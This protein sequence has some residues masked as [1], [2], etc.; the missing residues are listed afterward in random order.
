VIGQLDKLGPQ[1]TAALEVFLRIGDEA[2]LSQAYELGRLAM[3]GGLGVLDMAS[4]HH[5]ALGALFATISPAEQ[6]RLTRS[7]ADFFTELLSPFEMSIRGYRAANEKLQ[8]LNES[9]RQR[10]EAIEIANRE[11]EAFSYSVSHDLRA[12]LRTI[13]AFSDFVLE[14]CGPALGDT[15]TR[16]VQRIRDAAQH[17]GVL[18]DSML[19][20][21]R[22]TRSELRRVEVDLTGLAW[23]II[24]EL[25]TTAPRREVRF[26]VEQDVYG[27]GDPSLLSVVMEN[28]LGNAWKFTSHRSHAEIRFG[29]VPS[30]GPAT[31]F[32]RDNGAGFDMA[33][34]E[35]LF[36]PFQRLHS[37]T[38]FEG[39][40]IGLATVQRVIERHSGRIWAESALD[41]GAT[42]YFTL[43]GG[44]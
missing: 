12:P 27:D 16:H 20:L 7:A 9:L 2:S 44:R 34:V 25:R 35:K 17:M 29:R 8:Q 32:V 18:I 10:N 24:E 41:L 5:A 13:S 28:L 36:S 42:F 23:Q 33:L 19:S 26:I 11:L 1:Y 37:P 21:A 43:S 6:L 3:V 15:S 40:G 38:E 30:D 31:Y 39:T 14:D 4:L 22:V